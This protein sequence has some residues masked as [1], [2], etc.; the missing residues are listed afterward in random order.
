MRSFENLVTRQ[1]ITLKKLDLD[2]ST[3]KPEI[4]S[5]DTGQRMP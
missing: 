1:R 5:G 4:R 3:P 2:G